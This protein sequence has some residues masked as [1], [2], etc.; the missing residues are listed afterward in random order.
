MLDRPPEVFGNAGMDA[1]NTLDISKWM[2]KPIIPLNDAWEEVR[3]KYT[4]D[5]WKVKS[6]WT[7]GVLDA[8]N[9]GRQALILIDK[10]GFSGKSVEAK[11]LTDVIGQ[12][13]VGSL[14]KDT[15]TN[16]F[17]FSKLWDKRLIIAGDSKNPRIIRG[18]KVHSILGSDQVDVEY[19]GRS[20]FSWQIKAKLL[21][22]TNSSIEID[23]T[24]AHERTRVIILKP[25]VNDE[26]LKK[27]AVTNDDGELVLDQYGNPK[28]K[29]DATFGKRLFEGID[30][31]L[32]QAYHYYC[33][34]CP[35][36]SELILPDSIL[37]N[38]YEI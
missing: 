32:I 33:E 13:L 30:A 38:I 1:I 14:C 23:P 31:Y 10:Q 2:D 8:R 25:K 5:E 29:G 4:E 36:H 19:K 12:N 34:L 18:E 22:N 3:S 11:V 17:G 16:Q 27:M 6:A 35:N 28:L 26:L 15:L 7:W 20:S 24:A 9:T 21:I 37:D